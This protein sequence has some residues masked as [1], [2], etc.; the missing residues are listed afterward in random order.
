MEQQK[1]VRKFTHSV[2]ILAH[3]YLSFNCIGSCGIYVKLLSDTKC[4]FPSSVHFLLHICFR[5]IKCLVS[6]AWVACRNVC[7]HSCEVFGGYWLD[8][9]QSLDVSISFSKTVISARKADGKTHM[10]KRI[11]AF[12]NCSF[13]RRQGTQN[14]NF[15]TPARTRAPNL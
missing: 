6:Q 2:T 3:S 5:S 9:N 12:R 15:R 13:R 10:A 7:R 11:S 14:F 8:F 4:V 1:Q